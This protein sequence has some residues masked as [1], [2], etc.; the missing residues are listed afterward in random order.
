MPFVI[1][2][3]GVDGPKEADD[4]MHWFRKAQAEAAE[5][6][7][8]KGNVVAVMTEEC[9]D[10]EAQRIHRKLQKATEERFKS[11]GERMGPRAASKKKNRL[12]QE[13]MPKIL[14]AEELKIKQEGE[15]NAGFHYNGSAYIYG[16][17]GKEFAEA[18]IELDANQ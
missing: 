18:L 9:W 8:F 12:Y 14:T 7:E 13:L 15:S 1:G 5:L 17:I 11:S 3:L 10:V 16:K 6:L 2:V 4:N